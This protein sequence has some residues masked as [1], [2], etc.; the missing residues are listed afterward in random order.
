MSDVKNVPLKST[1]NDFKEGKNKVL[2]ED[3]AELNAAAA[4]VISM[5]SLQQEFERDVRKEFGTSEVEVGTI[6]YEADRLAAKEAEKTRTITV[7][8]DVTNTDRKYIHELSRNLGLKNTSASKGESRCITV[9]EQI[10][11]GVFKRVRVRIPD[12]DVGGRQ[13]ELGAR[14]VVDSMPYVHSVSSVY[15]ADKVFKG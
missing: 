5:E 7:P 6:S 13:V 14:L 8:T 2:N 11:T 15:K 12:T 1:P 10:N 9:T 3:Q 4:P